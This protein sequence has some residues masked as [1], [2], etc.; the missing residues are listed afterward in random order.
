MTVTVSG[1]GDSGA[2]DAPVAGNLS[3]DYRSLLQKKCRAGQTV[4]CRANCAILYCA[5]QTVIYCI[6]QSKLCYTVLCRA[7]QT[8]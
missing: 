1:E 8:V 2:Q 5:E 7:W 6:V 3:H 4:L